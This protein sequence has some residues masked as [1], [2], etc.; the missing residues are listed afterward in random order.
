MALSKAAL[1]SEE[2]LI[3]RTK[4]SSNHQAIRYNVGW[5]TQR[6]HLLAKVQQKMPHG[7][8]IA[9]VGRV[10][11]LALSRQ[12]FRLSFKL[13]SKSTFCHGNL[14]NEL[15][16]FPKRERES[17]E[18]GGKAGWE[19]VWWMRKRSFPWQPNIYGLFVPRISQGGPPGLL[20]DNLQEAVENRFI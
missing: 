16:P 20:I 18:G 19:L 8:S 2:G 5:M 1:D 4:T 7:S 10:S 11:N 3:I 17:C 6:A 13:R 12:S 15:G 14:L 9:V